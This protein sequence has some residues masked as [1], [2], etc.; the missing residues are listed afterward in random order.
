MRTCFPRRVLR[1]L[2]GGEWAG[3]SSLPHFLLS[4]LSSFSSRREFFLFF[5]ERALTTANVQCPL[6]Q[7]PV[8]EG[9]K[10]GKKEGGG[11]AP[12][13]G[14]AEG[15]SGVPSSGGAGADTRV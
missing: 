14:G 2:V 13:S 5:K 8:L 1:R 12:S 4:H 11:G 7:R 15:A 3:A 6:C 9:K 10:K